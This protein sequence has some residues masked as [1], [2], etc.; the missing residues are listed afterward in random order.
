MR[1]GIH[2]AGITIERVLNPTILPAR[3]FRGVVDTVFTLALG[4]ICAFALTLGPAPLNTLAASSDAPAAFEGVDQAAASGSLLPREIRT[5]SSTVHQREAANQ[6]STDRSSEAPPEGRIPVPETESQ[7]PGAHMPT[8]P[9]PALPIPAP[10]VPDVQSGAAVPSQAAAAALAI[11]ESYRTASGLKPFVDSVSCAVP[12]V[13]VTVHVTPS[14]LLP[15]GLAVTS[16]VP[17][18]AHASAQETG[19]GPVTVTVYTCK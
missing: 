11:V 15:I 17:D 9:A 13:H 2:G 12:L 19:G 16:L 3:R 1:A 18:P 8:V 7:S 5:D 14:E 6:R 10:I 4:S